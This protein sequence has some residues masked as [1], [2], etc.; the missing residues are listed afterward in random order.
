MPLFCLPGALLLGLTVN[1]VLLAQK[2]ATAVVKG[3]KV[4]TL[5]VPGRN[6]YCRIDPGGHSVLPSGR[7]VTPAG[8]TVRITRAPYGLALAPDG[9]TALVLHNGVITLLDARN[10]EKATR[11]PSYD[12]QVASALE[13]ASFLGVAF[14]KDSKTAY[15]SGGD[16]GNVVIFDLQKRVRTGEIKLDGTFD[17]TPYED[18]FT[19]DLLINPDRNEL[20]VL[21]RGNFRLVRIDLATQ[22]ITASVGVGRIPFGIALSPDRKTALVANV[23]L[24][25]YPAVPGVTPTNGDTMML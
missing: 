8:Q 9:A 15:L 4:I 5:Q 20:L 23:G 13:G 25:A 11:I 7:Y 3:K 16:K 14:A 6:E 24:Y 22:R 17:G 10:P 18:S 12:G 19:S 21:D 2:P 1:P